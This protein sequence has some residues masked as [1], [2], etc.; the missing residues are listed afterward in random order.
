MPKAKAKRTW[1]TLEERIQHA[2]D[3]LQRTYDR[4]EKILARIVVLRE[5]VDNLRAK[6]HEEPAAA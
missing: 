6:K 1:G 3:Y 4:S 5:R 2:E